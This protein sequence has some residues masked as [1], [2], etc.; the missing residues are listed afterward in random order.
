[1]YGSNGSVYKMVDITTDPRSQLIPKD[2][3]LDNRFNIGNDVYLLRNSLMIKL[4][5]LK[6]ESSIES[7]YILHKNKHIIIVDDKA[8]VFW[9]GRSVE[10]EKFNFLYSENEIDEKTKE[11]DE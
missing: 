9:E 8:Y 2:L 4:A 1:M 3:F 10:P 5:K 6:G 11:L 7:L